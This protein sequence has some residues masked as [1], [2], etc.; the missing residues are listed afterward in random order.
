MK[1]FKTHSDHE[2]KRIKKT[3]KQILELQP[4]Y[5]QLSDEQLKSKTEEFKQRLKEESLNDL[6]PEAYAAIREADKRVLGMEPF[7]VQI[8][9]GI[10]MS[11]GRVAE[12]CTGEG[13][14]L[15]CTLPAYLNALT[16][17]GVH[18]VTVNDYLAKRDS[19]QMGQVYE[20][21]G[22]SCGCITQDLSLIHI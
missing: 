7:P 9:G 16:G 14:T 11:Q 20:W 6:L 10:I 17:K 3:V 15:V 1:F 19:D 5:A 12:M 22:L 4:E 2:L 21:M 8:M 13:K 18:V